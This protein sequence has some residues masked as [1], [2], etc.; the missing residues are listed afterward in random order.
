ML[1][2]SNIYQNVVAEHLS[3]AEYREDGMDCGV[4]MSTDQII[5]D[6]FCNTTHNHYVCQSTGNGCLM[7]TSRE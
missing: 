1:L 3:D 6:V 5:G 4:L 7:F 2:Y